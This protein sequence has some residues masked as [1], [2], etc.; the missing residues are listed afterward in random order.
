MSPDREHLHHKIMSLGFEQ[1]T[2]LL[3]IYAVDLLFSCLVLSGLILKYR[4]FFSLLVVSWCIAVLGFIW[5]HFATNP[6]QRHE[7]YL[8]KKQPKPVRKDAKD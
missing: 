3:L 8:A 4:I 5:L 6:E 1:R 7:N 2:T